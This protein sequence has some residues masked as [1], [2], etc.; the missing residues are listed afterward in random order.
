MHFE[1]DGFPA[2]RDIAEPAP[3]AFSRVI[4]VG[5]CFDPRERDRVGDHLDELERLARTLGGRVVGRWLQ[6]RR[7]PDSATFI[8]RGKAEALGE[9]AR[10][11]R[12]GRIVFDDD[13][14]PGQARELE[15]LTG[16]RIVDRSGLI[17]DIF[18]DHA[19]TREARTQVQVAQLE[20]LLPRLAGAWTHL[21]RQRGGVTGMRGA[22]E[23]QIEIDRR[24]IRRKLARLRQ[25]LGRIEASRG[26]RRRRRDSLPRVAVVGYTNAG[27]SSLVNALTGSDCAVEDRLFSTLDPRVRGA[28]LG[29]HARALLVDTVGFLRKLPHHLIASFRSTLMESAEADLLLHVADACDPAL[30]EHLRVTRET[31]AE[32]GA[33]GKPELLVLNKADRISAEGARQRL[34]ALHPGA[35]WVSALRG[36]G[37]E[38]LRARLRG[39]LMEERPARRL[40]LPASRQDLVHR[41]YEM[42]QVTGQRYRRDRVLLDYRADSGQESR[43]RRALG[44]QHEGARRAEARA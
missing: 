23:Q 26:E 32:I 41:V 20:Y 37:V 5:V 24:L 22:G 28:A 9:A 35:V 36:W 1:R 3:D 38:D 11:K 29:P 14:T 13:L 18:S 42:V 33:G 2:P 40:S 44:R 6:E 15:R 12:A 31:L 34:R 30:D 21:E 27:K 17:L 39:L 16:A 19:R 4:L 10:D 25:A 8:G 7:R 43:L